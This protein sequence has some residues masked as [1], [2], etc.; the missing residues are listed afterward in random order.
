[1]RLAALAALAA[2]ALAVA[3]CRC[4]RDKPRS[5]T[6]LVLTVTDAGG[7][8]FEAYRQLFSGRAAGAETLARFADGHEA[9]LRAPYGK[10][11]VIWLSGFAGLAYHLAPDAQ[12][13]AFITALFDPRGY[14]C[15][16]ELD[17]QG[18]TVRLHQTESEYHAVCPVAM[19]LWRDRTG[20]ARSTFGSSSSTSRPAAAT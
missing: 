20:W 5:T 3:G 9:A 19:T 17:A 11:E 12:S 4:K 2:L 13:R 8:V 7:L 15:V 14:A 18:M 10:G 6:T 1:M 16:A